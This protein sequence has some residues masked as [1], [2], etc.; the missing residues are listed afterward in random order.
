MNPTLPFRRGNA[1]PAVSAGLLQVREKRPIR[2]LQLEREA[3]STQAGGLLVNHTGR[4]PV[5]LGMAKVNPRLLLN[6]QARIVS[7]LS[8]ANFNVDAHD[9]PLCLM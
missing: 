3:E 8:G 2:T 1:L 5:V 6:Q 9:A 4:N 7:T